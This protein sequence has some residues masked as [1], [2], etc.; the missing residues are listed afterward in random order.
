MYKC[1]GW[2][3]NEDVSKEFDS[4]VRKSLSFYDELQDMIV[5]MSDYFI[6]KYATIYDLGTAT[7][8]TLFRI[9]QRHPDKELNLIGIDISNEMLKKA[10]DKNLS[11]T[12]V[13]FEIANLEDYQFP[14]PSPLIYSVLTMHFLPI[15]KRKKLIEEVYQAL[16]PGGCF[17]FVDKI[18]NNTPQTQQMFTHLLYEEK[19]KAGFT[20]EEVLKKEESLRGTLIPLSLEQNLSLLQSVGFETDLF[21]LHYQFVGIIAI[22][23]DE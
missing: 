8:E 15:S 22:K 2:T 18:L 1:S 13:K 21:F 7:G 3:F 12:N 17:I 6:K 10:K 19:L 20:H 16:L 9:Q 14:S 11:F 4:H 23:K 5:A